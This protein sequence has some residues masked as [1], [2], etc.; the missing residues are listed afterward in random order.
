MFCLY[1]VIF[2]SITKCLEFTNC[3]FSQ[4]CNLFFVVCFQKIVRRLQLMGLTF[5]FCFAFIL[6]KVS[7][8]L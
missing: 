1:A 4:L 5:L 3:K 8:V 2:V 7:L 6:E